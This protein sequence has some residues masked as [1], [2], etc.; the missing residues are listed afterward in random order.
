MATLSE[1]IPP[2]RE[3]RQSDRGMRAQ[4]AGS[5]TKTCDF[6]MMIMCEEAAKEREM[7]CRG[8]LG[9]Y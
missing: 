4:E 6:D 7:K 2:F 3:Q 5:A 9:D 8:S 1:R